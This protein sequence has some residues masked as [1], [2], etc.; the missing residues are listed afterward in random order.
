MRAA[1]G[2]SFALAAAIAF[3]YGCSDDHSFFA[4]GSTASSSNA[5]SSGSGGAGGVGGATSSAGGAGA[6][7]ASSSSGGPI[8][9]SKLTIVDGIADYDAVRFCFLPASGDPS[10]VPWPSS[11]GLSFA[12]ASN[13][14]PIDSII[15]P[16][17]DVATLV[18]G[19]D[20]DATEGHTCGEIVDMANADGGA[21]IFAATLPTL[22]ASAFTSHESLLVVANGCLGGPTHSDANQTFGCGATYTGLGPNASLVAAGMDRGASPGV[23]A[24]QVVVAAQAANNA[25]IHL[26][27]GLKGSNEI[28]VATNLAPGSLS[29]QFAS[30]AESEYEPLDQASLRVYSPNAM[31]PSSIVAFGEI[32]GN[33]SVKEADFANGKAF[34]FVGVGG[35]P[36]Q[37][38]AD[39][40][41]QFTYVLVPADP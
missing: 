29:P 1:F 37:P 9:P 40:W 24:F 31:T 23:V 20:L 12:H 25:D 26:A 4:V 35:L 8:L 16:S 41:H 10:A 19:G 5:S 28:V 15:P 34:V 22:P 32:F 38:P 6:A 36:G 14:D 2:I 21:T 3:A 17:T 27:P 13:I 7:S 39:W 30:L 18:F 11:G 33:S